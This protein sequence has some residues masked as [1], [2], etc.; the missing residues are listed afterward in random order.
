MT[1]AWTLAGFAGVVLVS[2]ACGAACNALLRDWAGTAAL[3]SVVETVVYAMLVDLYL[4]RTV[5]LPLCAHYRCGA[6]PG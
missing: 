6:P 1:V 5:L 3:R 2:L 4:I